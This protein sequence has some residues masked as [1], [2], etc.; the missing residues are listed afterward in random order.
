MDDIL[1]LEDRDPNGINNHITVRHSG[2]TSHDNMQIDLL[3]NVNRL[4]GGSG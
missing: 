1:D 4:C 2:I 3:S